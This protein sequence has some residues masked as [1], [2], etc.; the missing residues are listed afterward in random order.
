[1]KIL[2]IILLLTLTLSCANKGDNDD[3]D[4]FSPR[5]DNGAVPPEDTTMQHYDSLTDKS[6]TGT[7]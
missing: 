3:K 5:Q 1:M 7:P 6:N 2:S 4:N